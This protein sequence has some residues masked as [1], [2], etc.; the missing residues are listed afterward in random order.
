MP[1]LDDV[2]T[3]GG[4]IE[5]HLA[6]TPV[7]RSA[8]LGRD[9]VLKLETLQPTGSFKVRGALVAVH[10][11]IERDAGVRIVT[12]SAGNH[13]LGVAFAATTYGAPATV[14]VPENASAAK[15]AALARYDIEL[16]TIGSSYD[17][18]EAHA[19]RLGESGAVF[20]SPYNDAETIAGQ[21]TIVGELIDQVPDVRTLVVP[22][23]G[24][25]L[26]S[27]IAL[28]ASAREGMRVV[29]VE[30]AASPAMV[31]AL[32]DG[33]SI[34]VGPTL[35]DGLAGNL[36]PGSVTVELC[37]RHVDEIVSV[38]EDEIGDA[39]RFLFAQHG[40]VVEGSGAVGVAALLHGRIANDDRATAVLL[41]GR[42]IAPDTF[43]RVLTG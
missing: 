33:S 11:A 16:V 29:G 41:T 1:T 32:G 19:L 2:V 34:T 38:T 31:A 42:N 10:H 5:R 25:G 15:R 7:V 8:D 14:V 9:V 3:A 13:G 37:R 40:L 17:E 4:I 20:V 35:A 30:A 23:G 36:E 6:P 43:A 28:A 12:A 39:M 22:I 26:I 27:G 24:G 21:G 18:A